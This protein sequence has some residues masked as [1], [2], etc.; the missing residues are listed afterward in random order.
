MAS[1]VAVN[2]FL[3]P[4][5]MVFFLVILMMPIVFFQLFARRAFECLGLSKVI[6]G[7]G[8]ATM[9]M[10]VASFVIAH[11]NVAS[12]LSLSVLLLIFVLPYTAL[13]VMPIAIWLTRKGMATVIALAGVGFM[14]GLIF[15]ACSSAFPRNNW[16]RTHRIEFFFDTFI[17][18]GFIAIIAAC[19]FAFGAR[20]PIRGA[21]H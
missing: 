10:F 18:S 2:L 13:V 17:F 21:K 1:D 19:A 4:L 3:S 11:G 7:Y 9:T 16:I 8:A 20:L 14:A 5:G 15:A 12:A 6:Q